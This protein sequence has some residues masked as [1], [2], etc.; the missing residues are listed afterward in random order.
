MAV[1]KISRN[2]QWDSVKKAFVLVCTIFEFFSISTDTKLSRPHLYGYEGRKTSGLFKRNETTSLLNVRESIHLRKKFIQSRLIR[3][4]PP[5]FCMHVYMHRSTQMC[6]I[7]SAEYIYILDS[8]S[9]T[10]PRNRERANIFAL[11]YNVTPTRNRAARLDVIYFI[12]YL[13]IINGKKIF[14]VYRICTKVM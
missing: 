11:F 13:L 14:L 1:L 6:D 5:T 9:T 8:L 7:S 4:R 2:A 12:I 3:C 10:I